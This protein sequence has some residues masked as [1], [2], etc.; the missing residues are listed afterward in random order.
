MRIIYQVLGGRLPFGCMSELQVSRAQQ[1]ES[2][3]EGWHY[4]P[5]TAVVERLCRSVLSA[6]YKCG[7]GRVREWVMV[8]RDQMKEQTNPEAADHAS[9]CIRVMG[10]VSL[11]SDKGATWMQK[12]GSQNTCTS[13]KL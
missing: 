6:A 5:E 3:Q 10:W 9:D 2:V 8:S 1:V 7:G 13:P 12:A 11:S 4:A